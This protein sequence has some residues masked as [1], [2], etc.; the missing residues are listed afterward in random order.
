MLQKDHINKK[1]T[2]VLRLKDDDDNHHFVD[3]QFVDFDIQN[4]K[5]WTKCSIIKF[6]NKCID[7][8]IYKD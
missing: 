2:Y 5:F 7:A 6:D 3:N 4:T 8:Y 1:D